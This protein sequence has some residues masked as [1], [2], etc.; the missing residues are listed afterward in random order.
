MISSS[1][2]DFKFLSCYFEKSLERVI[3]GFLGGW[4]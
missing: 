2:I 3:S 1:G 4:G